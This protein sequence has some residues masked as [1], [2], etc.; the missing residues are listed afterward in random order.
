MYLRNVRV[1]GPVHAFICV[2]WR[3]YFNFLHRIERFKI[4]KAL[5]ARAV[6]ALTGHVEDHGPEQTGT[7]RRYGSLP[8]GS[9]HTTGPLLMPASKL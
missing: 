7:T 4:F 5:P 6:Q 3:I 1:R 9:H 8:T 2:R